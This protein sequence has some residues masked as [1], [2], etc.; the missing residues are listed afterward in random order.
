MSTHLIT[1]SFLLWVGAYFDTND[2]HH[3]YHYNG[4]IITNITITI[5]ITIITIIVIIIKV[6]RLFGGQCASSRGGGSGGDSAGQSVG[7][8]TLHVGLPHEE[9]QGAGGK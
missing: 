5:V 7:P 1:F 9:R 2:T 4:T 6:E 8:A 3:H